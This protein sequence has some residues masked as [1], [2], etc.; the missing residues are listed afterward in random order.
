VSVRIVVV[1]AQKSAAHVRELFRIIVPPVDSDSETQKVWQSGIVSSVFLQVLQG[2]TPSTIGAIPDPTACQ[3]SVL[4]SAASPWVVTNF[5]RLF[6]AYHERLACPVVADAGIGGSGSVETWYL[7]VKLPS[8][9][10]SPAQ[11]HRNQ[12]GHANRN[13]PGGS[14]ASQARVITTPTF[15]NELPSRA[16]RSGRDEAAGSGREAAVSEGLVEKFPSVTKKT[17]LKKFMRY[18]LFQ[19]CDFGT[20]WNKQK[21]TQKSDALTKIVDH[22]RRMREK[23]QPIPLP[24]MSEIAEYSWLSTVRLDEFVRT[25]N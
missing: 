24:E 7:V 8:E 3:I 12:V 22:L 16:P 23:G 14:A 21:I 25:R 11:P 20:W 17:H 15:S 5:E 10:F 2:R 19:Y 13:S 1:A 4:D 6:V 9:V 18:V